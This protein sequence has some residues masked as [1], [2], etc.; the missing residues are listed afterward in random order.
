ML[1]NIYESSGLA[2][3][4]LAEWMKSMLIL[5][6]PIDL[7]SPYNVRIIPSYAMI[8]L[9]YWLEAHGDS[10]GSR[11]GMRGCIP[12]PARHIGIL[13]HVVSECHTVLALLQ[14]RGKRRETVYSLVDY[15]VT[16]SVSV[17]WVVSDGWLRYYFV[18]Q[19]WRQ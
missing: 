18:L 9:T 12:P 6:I 5:Y 19:R 10:G 16:V 2:A 8:L 17:H 13:F 11:G 1:A 14:S 4:F 7:F 3:S 15:R